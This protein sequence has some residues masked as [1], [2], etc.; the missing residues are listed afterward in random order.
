MTFQGGARSLLG[1]WA[2]PQG[3]HAVSADECV[4]R[5]EVGH[6]LHCGCWYLDGFISSILKTRSIVKNCIERRKAYVD[7][8]NMLQVH[9]QW[10]G[11]EVG[12]GCNPLMH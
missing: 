2:M 1:V 7:H 5:W 12:L 4:L 8:G 6:V 9:I 11:W 3:L 10:N